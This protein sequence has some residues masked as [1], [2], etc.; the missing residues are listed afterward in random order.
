VND[1]VGTS[2][3][4]YKLFITF[5]KVLGLAVYWDHALG[6]NLP[7]FNRMLLEEIPSIDDMQLIDKSY[8]N[9]LKIL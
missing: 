8:Y 6:A 1:L 7:A 3:E 9:S 4:T 2:D 5:G